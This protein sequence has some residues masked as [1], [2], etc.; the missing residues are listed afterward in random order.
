MARRGRF[1]AIE[2]T[3]GS[4]K[5][6][7]ARLLALALRRLRRRVHVIGFPQYGKPSAAPVEAFLNGDYGTGL[8]VGPYRASVLYAA[9][10]VAA[11]QQILNWLADG[12][13]VIADRYTASSLA[14]QGWKISN[15]ALRR[16]FWTWLENFEYVTLGL[17]R[18]DRTIVLMVPPST[19]RQ[20]VLKKKQRAYIRG[21]R[22]RDMVE[23]DRVYQQKSYEVYRELCRR[24]RRFRAIDCAPQGKLIGKTEVR[25]KVVAALRG[26]VLN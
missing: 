26:V 10:R 1:I 21:G 7:Q 8:A 11:R 17:P 19:S 18:P 15:P 23:R 6:T 5:A 12:D 14:H 4:G 22:R 13:I 3:D 9:D 24:D 16:R 20:L 2:G 25:D